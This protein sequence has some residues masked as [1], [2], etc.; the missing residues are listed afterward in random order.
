M[1][2]RKLCDLET[3]ERCVIVGTLFKHM[4][5]QPSILKEISEEVGKIK[6]KKNTHTHGGKKVRTVT[7]SSVCVFLPDP[8]PIINI[9]LV[10]FCVSAELFVTW[11]VVLWRSSTTCSRSPLEPNTSANQ[12]S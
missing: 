3:G 10:T 11:S 1:P 6:K 7:W 12:T 9:V 8:A 2:I 5:L 4:E